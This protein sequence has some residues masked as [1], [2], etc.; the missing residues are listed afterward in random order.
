MIAGTSASWYCIPRRCRISSAKNAEP[1][2]A[3]NS[4]ANAAAIPAIVRH[5]VSIAFER[6]H[7]RASSRV[8]RTS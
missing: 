6:R 2:G 3:P 1:I 4:T 7:A 5:R 8:C